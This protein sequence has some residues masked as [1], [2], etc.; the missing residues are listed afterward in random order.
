MADNGVASMGMGTVAAA[1]ICVVSS[2]GSKQTGPK[3]ND[4]FPRQSDS[5]RKLAP[6]SRRVGGIIM[7]A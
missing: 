2:S 4:L 1:L 6:S 5:R 3:K 7:I